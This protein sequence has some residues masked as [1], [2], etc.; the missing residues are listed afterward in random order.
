M[1]FSFLFFLENVWITS[2]VVTLISFFL[3]DRCGSGEKKFE[4]PIF[5]Y[6]LFLYKL[7]ISRRK[8][9]NTGF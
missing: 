2:V 9:A 6:L 8:G 1:K 3:F 4:T 7:W 5:A